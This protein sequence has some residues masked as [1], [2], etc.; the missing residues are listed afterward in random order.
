MYRSAP[1]EDLDNLHTAD[2]F[3]VEC[4]K[5]HRLR[6]RVD[7]MLYRAR[8]EESIVMLEDVSRL[9]SFRRTR[10]DSQFRFRMRGKCWKRR[11][12]C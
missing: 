3:L 9:I 6:P 4:L 1:I 11:R 7:G 8:F 12:R 10:A 5:I 2:R